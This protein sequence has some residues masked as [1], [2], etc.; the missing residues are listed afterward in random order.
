MKTLFYLLV[1]SSLFWNTQTEPV[2]YQLDTGHTFVGF[3]VE[4]FMVG[5]VSGWFEDF[6]ATITME[7]EDYTT[8]Q[9]NTTIQAESLDSNNDIRDSHLKGGMWLAT[10]MYPTITFQ[11]TAVR[12]EKPGEYV[13][14]GDFTIKGVTNTVSFP[15]EILGPFKDPTQK[16][17]L[18]L[19]ADF[20]IDRF[21][22]GIQFN[23]TMDNGELF[24]GR[25]VKIKIR[26]LAYQE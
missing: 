25:E 9:V 26:A 7:G 11:S 15:V 18:G 16:M 12:E 10:E 17:T 14:D 21:D 5:E 19:K 6:T 24:I 13:M 3:D 22:Y 2:T 1:A 8:L 4:R 23:K 20:S